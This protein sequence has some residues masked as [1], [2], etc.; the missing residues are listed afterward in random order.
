MDYFSLIEA[1]QFSLCFFLSEKI[2]GGGNPVRRKLK[3][4]RSLAALAEVRQE[5]E[6]KSMKKVGKRKA[7]G[8]CQRCGARSRQPDS[9]RGRTR[10]C[11]PRVELRAPD[12]VETL[13]IVAASGA[14]SRTITGLPASWEIDT[15]KIR[16]RFLRSYF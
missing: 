8:H 7:A 11:D 14:N 3:N 16:Q 9:F 6:M 4:G 5:N 10:P 2:P 1:Q 13:E 15:A 12:P